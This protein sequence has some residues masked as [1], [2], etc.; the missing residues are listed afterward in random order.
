M[1]TI[2]KS[3]LV[4]HSA[5]QMFALVNDIESYSQFL[6]WCRSST[7]LSRSEDEVRAQLE[8]AKGA[9]HKTFTTVNR[10]QKDKIME[11]RLVEGPFQHL[12][13]FWRPEVAP[14]P[15]SLEEDPL[16]PV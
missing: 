12:E 14:L 11:M 9:V 10:L 1:P 16:F 4:H 15:P 2:K 8:L 13:G 5:A 3:A 7:V 6:P